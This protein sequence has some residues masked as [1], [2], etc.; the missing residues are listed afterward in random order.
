MKVNK[1]YAIILAAGD[2]TRFNTQGVK[3]SSWNFMVRHFGNISMTPRQ[4]Y[5]RKII[6]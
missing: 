1:I 3:N 4:H 2:A 5:Y 6:L